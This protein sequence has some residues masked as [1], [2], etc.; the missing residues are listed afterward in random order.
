MITD[1]LIWQE[2]SGEVHISELFGDMD[3]VDCVYAAD[4]VS[5]FRA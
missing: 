2:G 5:L 3:F 4:V 1:V